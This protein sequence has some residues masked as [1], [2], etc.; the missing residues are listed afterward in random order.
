MCRAFSCV[1]TRNG[2]C[3]WQ[4][5]IDSHDELNSK[6]KVRD[7]TVDMEEISH[8]KIEIIPNPK[9]AKAKKYPYLYPDEPWVLQIDEKV[10]PSWIMQTHKDSA[11]KAWAEWKQTIYKFDYEQVRNPIN[12][13]KIKNKVTDID[14]QNLKRWASVWA[15]VGDSVWDSV[16]ASVGDSV[17][18]SVWASVR[19]SVGAYISGMF[20]EIKEWKYAEKLGEHPYQPCIDLWNRGFVPSFDGTTWRLHSGKKA[21]VVYEITKE[22]LQEVT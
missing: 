8:A 10:T 12:P 6:F 18:D 19:D 3:Y 17:R 13:L 4:S 20:P 21:K 7:D 14:I 2:K 11:W 1:V 15:S 16:W 5:G 9:S 22:K